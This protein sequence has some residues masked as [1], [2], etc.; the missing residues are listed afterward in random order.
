[1]STHVATLWLA[2]TYAVLSSTNHTSMPSHAA[3]VISNQVS[4][5]PFALKPC[6]KDKRKLPWQGIMCDTTQHLSATAMQNMALVAVVVKLVLWHRESHAHTS[7]DILLSVLP[8]QSDCYWVMMSLAAGQMLR[9]KVST[10]TAHLS[11]CSPLCQETDRKYAIPATALIDHAF[12]QLLTRQLA[13]CG[14]FIT[15]DIKIAAGDNGVLRQLGNGSMPC[16]LVFS[17]TGSG[18]IFCQR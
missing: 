11:I 17:A 5:L 13:V 6:L 9:Y 18:S 12:G 7:W 3:G 10:V 16:M 15:K 14:K 8:R 2:R 1:M 4:I